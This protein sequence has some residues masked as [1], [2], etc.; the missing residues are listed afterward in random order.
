[1]GPV[2]PPSS[3]SRVC[4]DCSGEKSLGAIRC[5]RCKTA[6]ERVRYDDLTDASFHN[7]V[8][9][10]GLATTFMGRYWEG[11]TL[12]RI[13]RAAWRW[14]R[15]YGPIPDGYTI[16]HL[17]AVTDDSLHQLACVTH[18][19]AA[20]KAWRTQTTRECDWCGDNMGLVPTQRKYCGRQC[21]NE[22]CSVTRPVCAL[23]GCTK[24]C[25]RASRTFCST[26]CRNKHGWVTASCTQCKKKFQHV[27]SR[28][29]KFCGNDCSRIHRR[30][31]AVKRR[32]QI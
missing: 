17:G 5:R 19:Q 31:L 30:L 8:R 6:R 15:A 1:M 2:K 16:I 12:I 14:R 13:G 10:S 22:S 7:T 21:A 24:R 3:K 27:R 9:P 18:A 28:P 23:D 32:Y 29:K 25:A 26:V 4:P 20:R 11:D